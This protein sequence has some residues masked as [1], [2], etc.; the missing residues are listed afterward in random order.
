MKIIKRLVLISLLLLFI[1]LNII[2]CKNYR[3]LNTYRYDSMYIFNDLNNIIAID[4]DEG[5]LSILNTNK[6]QEGKYVLNLIEKKNLN[7]KYISS[8]EYVFIYIY[9]ENFE[10]LYSI[11][12]DDSLSF[13][14]IFNT[15]D[16]VNKSPQ[17]LNFNDYLFFYNK[18]DN[19]YAVRIKENEVSFIDYNIKFDNNIYNLNNYGY[20]YKI[21]NAEKCFDN[22][23]YKKKC[24]ES[25]YNDI[26][27]RG[28]FIISNANQI[29]FYNKHSK[30]YIQTVFNSKVYE[31]YAN[32][33][34]DKDDKL[35]LLV[36]QKDK[37]GRLIPYIIYLSPIEDYKISLESLKT[38][39]T[40]SKKYV[41]NSLYTND[42]YLCASGGM[43]SDNKIISSCYYLN[44][45]ESVYEIDNMK[46]NFYNNSIIDDIIYA[47]KLR[48]ITFLIVINSVFITVFI[49]LYKYLKKIKNI[50]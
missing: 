19:L 4:I 42:L 50:T 1:L 45:S 40:K 30:E 21:N 28:E 47:S 22:S 46:I 20:M 9:N 6:T 7:I 3:Y 39:Y 33:F 27:Y 13:N 14:I 43:S 37:I 44:T 17:Y 25:K 31:Y 38:S 35:R 5:L 23:K 11:S 29:N 34:I 10:S 48:F 24:N 32:I 18:L 16:V 41:L 36:G 15:E 2:N 8:E 49:I 26:N 12:T